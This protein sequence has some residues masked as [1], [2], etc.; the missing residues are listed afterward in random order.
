MFLQDTGGS[1]NPSPLNI[2]N[3]GGVFVVLVAGLV[4]SCFMALFELLR[5]V[6]ETAREKKASVWKH[7]VK[8]VII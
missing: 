3:V 1:G 2:Q 4:L 7:S 6:Y 8:S 5:N